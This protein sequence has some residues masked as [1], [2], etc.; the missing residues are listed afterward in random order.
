M[1]Y[2]VS[3]H[4]RIVNGTDVLIVAWGGSC[5]DGESVSRDRAGGKG[6]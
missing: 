3:Y 5:A 6:R 2:E 4:G 1:E